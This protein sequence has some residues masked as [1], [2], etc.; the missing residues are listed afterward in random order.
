M[1]RRPVA[2]DQGR[3]VDPGSAGP[4]TWP[5]GRLLSMA[6]RRVERSWDAYLEQWSLTHATLPVLAVLSAGPRSQREV[7]RALKVTEQTTSRMLV[8]LEQVGYLRR[9]PH[10]AD[11]RR[12]VVAL[13]DAGLAALRAIDDPTVLERMVSASLTADQVGE[14]RAMLLT[15]IDAERAPGGQGGEADGQRAGV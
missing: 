2:Q 1:T 4:E 8:G 15:I 13:T 14:L 10:A 3:A 12:H 5:T 9:E 7:A 6:A 11:R